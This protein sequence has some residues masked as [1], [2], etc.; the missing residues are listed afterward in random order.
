VQT[1]SSLTPIDGHFRRPVETPF[2][3]MAYTGKKHKQVIGTDF[4]VIN[5]RQINP[6]NPIF[7]IFVDNSGYKYQ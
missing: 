1:V 7:L 6:I 5:V 4:V 2:Q 3:S